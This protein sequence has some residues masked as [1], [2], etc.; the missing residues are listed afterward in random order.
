MSVMLLLIV[1][2][3]RFGYCLWHRIRLRP[4]RLVDDSVIRVASARLFGVRSHLPILGRTR[5][6]IWTLGKFDRI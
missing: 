2:L 5:S 6:H 3:S 1:V 4:Y